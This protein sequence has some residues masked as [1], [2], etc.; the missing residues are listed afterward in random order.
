MLLVVSKMFERI[1]HDQFNLYLCDHSLI[2]EFQSGFRSL[3]SMNTALTDLSDKI[4]FN[5]DKGL[6]T[7]V[8]L[9]D[10]QK[11]FDMVDHQILL[12]QLKTIAAGDNAVN[13][14]LSDRSQFVD[15]FNLQ[16]S[17]QMGLWP[18]RIQW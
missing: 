15:V 3:F 9:V 16:S 13:L 2:Y 8:I 12:K 14:Y 11:S 7:G 18:S 10:L 1:V 17:I 6:Y 5:M 4:H